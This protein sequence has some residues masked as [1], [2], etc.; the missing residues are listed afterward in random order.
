MLFLGAY[1]IEPARHGGQKRSKEIQ[2]YCASLG[3]EVSYLGFCSDGYRSIGRNDHYISK[4]VELSSFESALLSDLVIA[5]KLPSTR[6]LELV[7]RTIEKRRPSAI[8]LEQPWCWP[9]VQKALTELGLKLPVIYSSQN[10][11][12]RLK[13]KILLHQ[14]VSKKDTQETCQRIYRLETELTQQAALGIAVT[15]QD[16]EEM[17]AW[18]GK[19]AILVP[20]RNRL[21][22]QTKAPRNFE[23][24][25]GKYALF[26]GSGHPPNAE[27]LFHYLSDHFGFLSPDHRLVLAGG[28]ADLVAGSDEFYRHH[29]INNRR[30]L[31]IPSPDDSELAWLLRN[32]GCVILPIHSGE[33]SN[34]KTAE[35]LM[36]GRPVIS[37]RHA[38]R[39]YEEY[40]NH[41]LLTLADNSRE[42]K[43][44]VQ[45]ALLSSK[46][47]VR[48]EE[49]HA[50]AGRLSW[51]SALQPL[52]LGLSA[53]LS[54]N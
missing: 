15:Q 2:A 32:A 42:F 10:I 16:S 38:M 22:P 46:V 6:A 49:I 36:S 45:G 29:V 47:T 31:L 25:K 44:A 19:K 43:K 21:S 41:P 40:I 3:Y 18:G 34:L 52:A 5:E 8:V 14:G 50:I 26:V 12:F 54:S 51:E 24:W 23:I 30:I 28:V 7:K 53:A 33:G 4:F 48:D 37:S 11:E 35:A 17:A 1:P 27:G 9:L 39:G 13:E 20:N